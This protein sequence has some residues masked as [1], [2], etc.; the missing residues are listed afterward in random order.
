MKSVW[1]SPMDFKYLFQDDLEYNVA[2][3]YLTLK[4]LSQIT[5]EDAIEVAKMMAASSSVYLHYEKTEW[6]V[7]R[8]NAIGR[9]IWVYE[10]NRV[11][12][13]AVSVCYIN[14]SGS[15]Y[16]KT[17]SGIRL[18]C[19]ELRIY[20]FLRSRGYALPWM[21]LSI[22]E[23]VNSG[24]IKFE[25]NQTIEID[26]NIESDIE[27]ICDK[28]CDDVNI[29]NEYIGKVFQWLIDNKYYIVK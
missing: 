10:K 21:G 16:F 20:D 6:G 18:Y 9:Q 5:D 3:T 19:D 1:D 23:M 17:E 26:S 22:E 7:D 28:C 12:N 27:D 24:W 14:L 25:K 11:G 29:N 4:P 13:T 2:S 8:K 15:V